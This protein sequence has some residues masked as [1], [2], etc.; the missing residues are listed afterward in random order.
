MPVFLQILKAADTAFFL[1]LIDLQQHAQALA[2][3]LVIAQ[4]AHTGGPLQ[5]L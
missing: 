3:Q 4:L 1:G 2:Q 5:P